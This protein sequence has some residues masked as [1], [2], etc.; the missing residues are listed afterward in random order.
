MK[1]LTILII[2][3]LLLGSCKKDNESPT[4]YQVKNTS[5]I[6]IDNVMS[7]HLK[8]GQK[9]DLISHG[10]LSIG[11]ITSKTETDHEYINITFSMLNNQFNVVSPYNI[12]NNQNNILEITGSTIVQHVK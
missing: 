11:A 8:D 10:N 6:G 5:S 9:F 7:Y 1:H 12:K 3:V 4:T 2:A